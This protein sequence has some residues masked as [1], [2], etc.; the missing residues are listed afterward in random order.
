MVNVHTTFGFQFHEN[1]ALLVCCRDEAFYSYFGER[2]LSTLQVHVPAPEA[3]RQVNV[4]G[5]AHVGF[6]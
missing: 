3:F 2:S 5:T 4:F 6:V 1:F